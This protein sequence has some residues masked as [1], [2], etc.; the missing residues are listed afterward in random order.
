ML[1][2]NVES[3]FAIPLGM[4][5]L[6]S[7]APLLFEGCAKDWSKPLSMLLRPGGKPAVGCV[8]LLAVDG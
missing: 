7:V 5:G 2:A 4:A 3:R 6:L 1:P 8:V